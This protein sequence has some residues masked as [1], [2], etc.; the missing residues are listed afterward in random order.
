MSLT[1]R[2]A[3]SV[4]ELTGSIEG[5]MMS[6]EL[7]PYLEELNSKLEMGISSPLGVI[8]ELCHA[9]GIM[10]ELKEWLEYILRPVLPALELGVKGALIT[11]LMSSI[12]CNSNPMIPN[13]LRE[14]FFNESF[15]FD[16]N[17]LVSIMSTVASSGTT[18]IVEGGN[19]DVVN[20]VPANMY[21][22]EQTRYQGA[23]LNIPV[24]GIDFRGMLNYSPYKQVV[25]VPH[26]ETQVD[27]QTNKRKT[28]TVWEQKAGAEV[29]WKERIASNTW[30]YSTLYFGVNQ[31]TDNHPQAELCRATD[32]NAFLWYAKNKADLNP[33]I[34]VNSVS[35]ISSTLLPASAR[36]FDVLDVTHPVGQFKNVRNGAVV[37][38]T[39]ATNCSIVTNVVYDPQTK[40]VT[41]FRLMPVSSRSLNA[42]TANL[43]WYVNPKSY[44][45]ENLF[46]GV[47]ESQESY[48]DYK[49]DK[50]LFNL[51]SNDGQTLNFHILPKPF[52]KYPYINENFKKAD[53]IVKILFDG[54]GQ[55][56][57]KH[58][59]FSVS[60]WCVNENV[61]YQLLDNDILE[62][63][64]RDNNDNKSNDV[65]LRVK[66]G[67]YNY[68]LWDVANNK[69]LANDEQKLSSVLYECY[70]GLTVYQF[71]YD[72]IMGQRL[73][74]S[75]SLLTS[76]MTN[77]F[78]LN[79]DVNLT[80]EFEAAKE[81]IAML[82]NNIIDSEPGLDTCFFTFDNVEQDRQL[83]NSI[84]R[85]AGGYKFD[86]GTTHQL[87]SDTQKK[88]REYLESLEGETEPQQRE[89]L[90]NVFQ[91]ITAD[92]S[93]GTGASY[94]IA[95]TDFIKQMI[96]QMVYEVVINSVFAP[97]ILMCIQVSNYIVGKNNSDVDLGV[98]LEQLLDSCLGLLYNIIKEVVNL[99]LQELLDWVMSKIGPIVALF[100]SGILAEYLDIYLKLITKIIDECGFKIKGFDGKIDD[101][102]FAE[103]EN[104]TGIPKIEN[105]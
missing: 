69:Y 65:T 86:D 41:K 38:Y 72:Y 22:F 90:E 17:K 89:G 60:P 50:P 75:K 32:M 51:R 93:G 37:S 52:V 48:R 4:K 84:K 104:T 36:L 18:G 53:T 47:V 92:L 40:E 14:F 100:T 3:D 94:K 68:Y 26:V 83:Q 76:L 87:S 77:L 80:M 12:S 15:S 56:D 25:N 10:N 97:K 99:L 31:D 91:Y 44:W 11:N 73:F 1:N 30:D 19:A 88:I 45:T 101:V 49:K 42:Y 78:G 62:Y 55:K 96:T 67:S 34:T 70:A 98:N 66:L 57:Q 102:R 8:F 9:M 81:K 71:F 61:E 39:N 6:I 103:I 7:L 59:R 64:L 28:R 95:E 16:P 85:K 13:E 33:V 29:D 35:D 105:C 46:G 20:N 5:M 23:G 2:A 21:G 63:T 24:S 43:N 54:Y 79:V 27:P 74:S 82:V 58:G